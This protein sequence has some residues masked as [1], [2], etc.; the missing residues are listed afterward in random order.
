M[1]EPLKVF[2]YIGTLIFLVGFA[3]AMRI[4]FYYFEGE[5]SRHVAGAVAATMLMIVG[6]QIVLI[7]L[8][9]DAIS[10]SRKL[11]EDVL[12]RLRKMELDDLARGRR[13]RERPVMADSA[14]RFRRDSRVQRGRRDSRCHRRTAVRRAVA[15]DHRR[16]RRIHG[17]HGRGGA[18]AP[19][20][21]SCAIRTTR[22]TAPR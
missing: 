14:D 6:F 16:R 21:A 2:S 12:Y 13:G 17:R 5:A 3:L 9:A 18:A 15:R 19:A 1:Y 8:V 4:V 20:R 22:A 7:G 11:T 10:S